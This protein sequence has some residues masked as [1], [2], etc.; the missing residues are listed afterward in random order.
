[1]E[2]IKLS[3]DITNPSEFHNLGIELW[4]DKAKFFDSLIAPGTHH[5]I[6][7]FEVEEGDH[8]FKIKFKNKNKNK[9]NEHT[10]INE[11]GSI[12]SDALINVSN[13]WLDEIKI[14]QLLYEKAEYVH[15]SNGLETIAVHPFY[16][17]F[18]CNGHVQ[19]KFSTP[20]YLWLLENM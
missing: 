20:I 7:E 4:I 9:S 16:G 5:I 18:G 1:M 12:I 14:D 2:K 3:L 15:D 19:L 11:D 8:S 13:I 6:H 10:K 17:N